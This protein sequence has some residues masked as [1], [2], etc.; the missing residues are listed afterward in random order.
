M[1][2]GSF[3]PVGNAR[4]VV[5]Q[6]GLRAGRFQNLS[7]LAVVGFVPVPEEHMTS[8]GSNDSHSRPTVDR[9]SGSSSSEQLN[10]QFLAR[11]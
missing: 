4:A 5:S 10:P 11:I 2:S 1:F 7:E 8:Q 6:I 9:L 3:D